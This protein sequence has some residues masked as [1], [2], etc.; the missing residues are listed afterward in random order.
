[1]K[2]VGSSTGERFRQ[3][4][5]AVQKQNPAVPKYRPK[6]ALNNYIIIFGKEEIS[7]VE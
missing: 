3:W 5:Y 1:V 2:S 6:H 7:E 4:L